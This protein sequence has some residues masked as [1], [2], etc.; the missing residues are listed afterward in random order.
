MS[1][2]LPPTSGG[3]AHPCAGFSVCNRP[4]S[5]AHCSERTDGSRATEREIREFEFRQKI[6]SAE[7]ASMLFFSLKN[8]I[9]KVS[10]IFIF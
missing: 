6:K 5:G 8:A 4:R 9:G 7:T 3:G 10:S 1:G 2:V